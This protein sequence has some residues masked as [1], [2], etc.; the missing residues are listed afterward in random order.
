MLTSG[1]SAEYGRFSGG[2]VNVITRS[3]GDVFSGGFRA[4]LSNPAWS[5]ETPFERANDVDRESKLSKYFETTL[6]GPVREGQ[7]WFYLAARNE[8]DSTEDVFGQTGVPF[9]STTKNDRF[10]IKLTGTPS[11]NHRLQGN[12]LNNTT[13][14]NEP[15]FPFSIDPA[16]IISPSLPSELVAANYNG[17]LA[18]RLFATAQASRKT[19]KVR[20][21]GG[22]STDLVDSP[23]LTLT[24]AFGHYNAPYFD[25]TDPQE[26]NNAQVAGSLSYFLPT[27]D[28]GWH[29]IKGGL[30]HFVSTMRGGNSQSATN[31]VFHADY[32]TDAGGAPVFDPRGRFVPVFVPGASLVEHYLAMRGSKIDIKTTSF[33]LQD[34]WAATD[35]LSLALGFRYERV[36]SDATGNIVGVDTDTIVPRVGASY[37]LGGDGR[38]VVYATYGHY[39]G[40]YN[41]LQFSRNTN[42]GNPDDL[43]GVYTGPAGAGRDF[44]AGF[45]PRNYQT[46]AGTF[47]TDNV[48]FDDD[49]SSPV[50]RELTL[51]GGAAFGSGGHA[52]LTYV[53]RTT[54]NFIEDFMDLDTGETT[55]VGDGQTFGTFANQV[56]RN[57]DVPRRG[58]QGIQLQARQTITSRWFVDGHWTV[59]LENDGNFE[60]EARNNP[61]ISSAFGNY[62]EIF[63]GARQFPEG[64]LSAFQRHK[65]RVWSGYDLGLGRYGDLDVTALWRYNSGLT[66]SLAATR[67]PL[68]SVQLDL[69]SGY[70]SH[71]ANQTLFFDER[72]SQQFKGY[73]LLDLA[74]QFRLPVR[75]SVS[76]WLKVEIFNALNNDT[77]IA[78]DTTVRPDAGS[79]TDALGLPTGYVEG[80]RFGEAT[81]NAHFPAPL[82][83]L[84]GGRT[85]RIAFGLRF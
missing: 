61:A 31:Y 78:W 22:T 25:A 82:P 29:D 19:F 43:I 85:L 2:V 55:V 63:T 56:Y 5:A 71:P 53:Y 64:R 11:A 73:G 65:V 81:S 49:L 75:D 52:K 8:R 42:I 59:Q 44:A 17:V 45:D 40:K 60:G 37:D 38:Y 32:Q 83:G 24:Q 66:Y 18:R 70:A 39:A 58:Y 12:Y 34:R 28:A 9:T 50:T 30:E 77:L 4:N 36:R 16:A 69:A 68:T 46:V 7:L 76:P 13:E 80:P 35:R 15:V 57:S 14:R 20:G 84:T 6:G 62:P 1:I 72:G 67:V 74:F 47:P 79:P 10:Q 41:G 23:F 48:F 33:Y 26:R 3:G 51:S 27:N 21:V 54:G